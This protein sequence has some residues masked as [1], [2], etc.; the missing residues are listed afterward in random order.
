MKEINLFRII[1][2]TLF[3]FF[4]I[5]GF[6]IRP[7]IETN[8]LKSIL[9]ENETSTLLLNLSNKTSAKVN[10]I[11]ESNDENILNDKITQVPE[12]WNHLTVSLIMTLP[13]PEAPP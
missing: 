6:V 12:I 7:D 1:F 10:I 11:I 9:P 5:A 4:I 13:P 8:I 2:A 3:A